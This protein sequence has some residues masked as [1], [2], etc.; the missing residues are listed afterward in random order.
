MHELSSH[1]FLTI[2]YVCRA[3]KTFA[4]NPLLIFVLDA[5]KAWISLHFV[6]LERTIP[7]QNKKKTCRGS[8]YPKSRFSAILLDSMR[9]SRLG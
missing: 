9:L 8:G 2:I 1:A 3:L 7:S 6:Y 4:E 5:L